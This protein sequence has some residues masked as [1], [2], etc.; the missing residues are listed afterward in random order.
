MIVSD[1]KKGRTVKPGNQSRFFQVLNKGNWKI[2]LQF[3]GVLKDELKKRGKIT[4][5][6]F[7]SKVLK[8]CSNFLCMCEDGHGQL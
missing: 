7:W 1:Q 5:G 8:L 4:E 3:T 6:R 2:K